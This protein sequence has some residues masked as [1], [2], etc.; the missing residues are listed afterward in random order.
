MNGYQI[1]RS[2]PIKPIP[3]ELDSMEELVLQKACI[4]RGSDVYLKEYVALEVNDSKPLK[5]VLLNYLSK[6]SG[7]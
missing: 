3:L 6:K 4:E 1:P 2:P 5:S 7:Y